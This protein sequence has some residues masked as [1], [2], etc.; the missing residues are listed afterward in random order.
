MSPVLL[1]LQ[2]IPVTYTVVGAD[3]VTL[4]EVRRVFL[5]CN[6]Q[7]RPGVNVCE[8]LRQVLDEDRGGA[9]KKESMKKGT[10][11]RID[12]WLDLISLSSRWA[13]RGGTWT[14]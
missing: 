5:V 3:N 6:L 4:H 9:H 11:E 1:V 7:G 14:P 8:C 13:F 10:S 12:S 2:F